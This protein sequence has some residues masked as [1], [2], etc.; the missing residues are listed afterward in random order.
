M[1]RE[2]FFTICRCCNQPLKNKGWQ[3]GLTPRSAGGFY[4]ECQIPGCP[5]FEVTSLDTCYIETTDLYPPYTSEEK[6]YA[7]TSSP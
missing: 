2:P 7:K 1:N 3:P 4:V 5:L 6:Q